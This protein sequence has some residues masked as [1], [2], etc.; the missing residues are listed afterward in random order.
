MKAEDNPEYLRQTKHAVEDFRAAL[1]EFLSLHVFNESFARGIYAAVWPKEDADP[2]EIQ[3]LQA[4]VSNAAGRASAATGLTGQWIMVQGGGPLDPIAAWVTI[5]QPKPLLE[6]PNIL[7]ACDQMLGR[8]DA[9]IAKA[10]AE[11]PPTIGAE[12]MHPLVWGAAK[13]LWRDR[14]FRQAV[15]AAAESLIAQVKARTSRYDLNDTPLWQEAFSERDPQPGKPRLRWPGDPTDKT[16]KTMNDG[17]R[18]FAPGVQMLIRNS[19]VHGEGDLPEQE[20]LERL[21]TLSQLARWTEVCV[22]AQAPD[23]SASTATAAGS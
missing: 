17:L 7:D 9:K 18:M 1:V 16:V 20:A 23:P 15:S 2:E 11:A 10:E 13:T 21:A 12:A 19:C 3:R 5:T 22:I 4:K 6:P 14:H 8:L